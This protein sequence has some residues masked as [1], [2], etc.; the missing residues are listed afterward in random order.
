MT[1]GTPSR[2]ASAGVWLSPL[3][4][5]LESVG[6]VADASP[7]P[8]PT[9]APCSLVLVQ[10]VA[11][12]SSTATRV[13]EATSLCMLVPEVGADRR[14]LAGDH[15]A[16][17]LSQVLMRIHAGRRATIRCVRDPA[18]PDGSTAR[19]DPS[20]LLHGAT[21]GVTPCRGS[22]TVR[23]R[24]SRGKSGRGQVKPLPPYSRPGRP[25]GPVMP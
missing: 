1:S 10:P 18:I 19:K 22:I 4:G 16:T 2:A 8:S 5:R 6:S 12:E 13:T 15:I 25:V 7:K 23:E 17:L 21:E 20:E 14:P 24:I 9:V 11:T 3:A